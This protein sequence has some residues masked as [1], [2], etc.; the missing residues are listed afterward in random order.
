M[1]GVLQRLV[2]WACRA[3]AGTRDFYS[4]LAALIS[5]QCK[6]FFFLSAHY[7]NLC[8]PIAQKPGKAVVQGRLSLNV[9]LCTPHTDKKENQMFLIYK[10][11]QK[12]RLQS[13]I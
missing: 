3:R 2:R 8:I 12:E 10:E 6:L 11:I 7:F 1:K 5:P 13:H 4:A 9:C